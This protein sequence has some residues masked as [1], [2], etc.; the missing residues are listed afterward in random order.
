MAVQPFTRRRA[1]RPVR[2]DIDTLRTKTWYGCV[3]SY[4][5]TDSAYSLEKHF[6]PEKVIV[7]N[8]ITKRPCKFDKYRRGE[9]TPSRRLVERIGEELPGT[10]KVFDH[11]FWDVARCPCTDIGMLHKQLSGLRPA[12]SNLLFYSPSRFE[13]TP[14]RRSQDYVPAFQTLGKEGDWDALT[15]CIGLIQELKYFGN[16]AFRFAYT[17]PTFR[18][19]LRFASS[20]PFYNLADEFYRYLLANIL[21][22]RVSKKLLDGITET[23]IFELA[24]ISG[25]RILIVED[26]D[27]LKR[28]FFTPKACLHIVERY[29]SAQI[30]YRL[31][32]HAR[33]GQWSE[34]YKMPEVRNLARALRRWEAK[35][36][37][38]D[39]D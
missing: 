6:S 2:G 30:V 13:E 20:T 15:A 28:H 34:I 37:R 11:V 10:K 32:D 21:N 22:N 33:A 17:R 24:S 29:L 38:P 12:I 19:F 4:L 14:Y 23:D 35:Q 25:S 18:I 3:A 26:L 5:G 16:D 7:E 1:G 36:P 27:L 39:T 8:G 31:R 9:H